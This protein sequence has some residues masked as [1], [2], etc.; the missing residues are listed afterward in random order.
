MGARASGAENVASHSS[1]PTRLPVVT[2]EISRTKP[3]TM[4]LRTRQSLSPSSSN[5]SGSVRSLVD[6]ATRYA[7]FCR[8]SGSADLACSMI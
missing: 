2:A 1:L 4:V 6:C 7:A 3:S 5:M 8:A